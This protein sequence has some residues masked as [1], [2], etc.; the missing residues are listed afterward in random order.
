MKKC[1]NCGKEYDNSWTTCLTDKTPLV[2]VPG[3]EDPKSNPA[4]TSAKKR[5]VGIIVIAVLLLLSGLSGSQALLGLLAP[6]PS[7]E[8]SAEQM[9]QQALATNPS[10]TKEQLE[11][12]TALETNPLVQSMVSAQDEFVKSGKY[13]G[14]SLSLGIYGLVSL[15]AGIGL[16]MSKEWARKLTIAGQFFGIAIY[17]LN[18]FFFSGIFKAA[19][20]NAPQTR[21]VL[22]VIFIVQGL[23]MGLIIWAIVSYLCRPQVRK[24]FV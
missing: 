20:A 24:W 8:F 10:L 3:T 13:Q 17:V 14:W 7:A 1:P 11:K 4:D 6:P 12:I 21:L 18:L 19:A 5:P 22:P 16:F 15:V 23:I 2:L 9:K